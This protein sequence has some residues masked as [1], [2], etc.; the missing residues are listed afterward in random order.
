MTPKCQHFLCI[1]LIS[2]LTSSVTSQDTIQQ[3][4]NYY[5]SQ[6]KLD[7]A[8]TYIKANLADKN[9]INYK[10]KL[11]YQ[12]VKVLFMQSSYEE[13]LQHAFSSIDN[14]ENENEKV[15]FNF[16]IGCIYSAI[17]DYKKSIE[18]F[19]LV[20]NYGDSPSLKVQTYLLL[21][22]LHVD[23]NDSISAEKQ[24]T[25]AYKITKNNNLNNKITD[26]VSMVYSFFK[27]NY[28]I[29]KQ[30][31]IKTIKDTTSFLNTRSYAYSMIGDCLIKQD[32]LN[33]A[34]IYFEK[35]LKLTFETKDPE[36][37]KVAA[38]KLIVVYEK[39]GKQEKANTYHKIYN[40][41]KDDSLSFSVEKYR[42]M[43]TIEKDR[44]LANAKSARIKKNYIIGGL[45][46]IFIF[47]ALY[48][49]TKRKN[50][51]KSPTKK[52]V[53][54]NSEIEKIDSAIETLKSKQQFLKANI[55]RKSFCTEYD[56][57]SERYLSEY[58]NDKYKKSFTVFLNDLRIEFAHDRLLNDHQFRNYKIEEI[59]KECGFGSK[60]SFERAF[61][62]KYDQ[63]P[64]KFITTLSN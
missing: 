56:I 33:E 14:I 39:L 54:N 16:L 43:Y 37:I 62:T 15:N 28:E 58:I 35:F 18:Y 9:H 10:N 32:S 34:S 23:L 13:A 64:F 6:V 44:E 25:K 38:K 26:H 12:L 2:L 30:Q 63:T 5:I 40:E 21:S 36:Q 4:I 3:K 45:S 1:I 48:F 7:S 17:K 11:N 29:C 41:A 22:E 52:I 31:N 53:I 27:K 24:L 42:D 55:S 57:K 46:V 20:V 60:K 61:I 49:N 47:I 19:N 59:A 50:S 8:K 51:K